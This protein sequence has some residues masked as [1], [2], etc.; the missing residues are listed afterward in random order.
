MGTIT[1]KVPQD[2]HLEYQIDN[3][4][5]MHSIPSSTKAVHQWEFKAQEN[6]T[7]LAMRKQVC[8]QKACSI[9]INVLC[10]GI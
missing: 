8:Y 3:L 10:K 4:K 9:S 7:Q 2:I 5:R 1:L 6:L